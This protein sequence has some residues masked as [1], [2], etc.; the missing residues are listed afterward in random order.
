MFNSLV[1]VE[2]EARNCDKC[3][4]CQN[5]KKAIFA[6]GNK[7]SDI[8]FIVDWPREE[9]ESSQDYWNSKGGKLLSQALIGQGIDKEKIYITSMIKCKVDGKEPKKE[10]IDT[11]LNYL[12]N[13][14]VVLKPKIIVL[15]GKVVI[16]EILGVDNQVSVVRGTSIERKG[17]TYIPTY[18]I[19][20][21]INDESK[22][23]ELWEDLDL[24]KSEC[25]KLNITI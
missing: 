9:E 8:M 11:C 1:E 6:N 17:I 7:E 16:K 21:L 2:N 4:L 12:R 3:S 23:I 15:M 13:Q 22:K 20:A 24:L 19:L 14:V 5:R 25:E 10:E 18:N